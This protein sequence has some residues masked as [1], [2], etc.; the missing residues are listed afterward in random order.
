MRTNISEL[1]NTLRSQDSYPL[2]F[3]RFH[4]ALILK[5]MD[6]SHDLKNSNEVLDQTEAYDCNLWQ[7]TSLQLHTL[8][9]AGRRAHV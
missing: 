5:A 7:S 9:I 4:S 8:R 2:Y 6:L 1:L 3:Q